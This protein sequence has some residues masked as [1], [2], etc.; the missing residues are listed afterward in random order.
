VGRNFR[1]FDEF[2]PSETFAATAPP[3][4]RSRF[5]PSP[6]AQHDLVFGLLA[7]Q[8]RSYHLNIAL[9]ELHAAK[10]RENSDPVTP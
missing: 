10:Q 1:D 7:L 4:T 6:G 3:P 2:R 9:R 8:V 5:G